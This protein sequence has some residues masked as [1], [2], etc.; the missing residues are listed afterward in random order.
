MLLFSL[1]HLCYCS[2][3]CTCAT[4]QLVAPGLRAVVLC[5]CSACCTCATVQLVAPGPRAVVLCYCLACCTWTVGCC[6]C[7]CSACCLQVKEINKYWH[8]AIQFDD[9]S[10]KKCYKVTCTNSINTW[11]SAKDVMLGLHDE[12]LVEQL[13]YPVGLINCSPKNCQKCRHPTEQFS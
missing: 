10:E 11:I 13:G 12:Q 9:H 6:L 4:A 3:C 1:L 7:Y 8:V 5:Y 2:A